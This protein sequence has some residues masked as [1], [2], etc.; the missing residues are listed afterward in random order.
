MKQFFKEIRLHKDNWQ[1][2]DKMEKLFNTVFG[3]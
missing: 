2:G 1:H 3:F